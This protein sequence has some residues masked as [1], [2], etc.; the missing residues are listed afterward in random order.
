MLRKS[1]EAILG[2]RIAESL[3]YAEMAQ[4]FGFH[5]SDMFKWVCNAVKPEKR[6]ELSF[7]EYVHMVSYFSMFTRAELIKFMFGNMDPDKLGYLFE[8]GWSKFCDI[9]AEEGPYNPAPWKKQFKNYYDKRLKMIFCAQFD[10]FS[11]QFP[12]S[13]WVAQEM[14]KKIKTFNLGE[15]F[16]EGK[17]NKYRIVREQAGINLIK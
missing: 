13:L 8:E 6:N 5:C 12:Q 14:Q 3:N 9:L 10:K 11:A 2:V 15:M 4:H 7:P 1:F 17:M 16:W